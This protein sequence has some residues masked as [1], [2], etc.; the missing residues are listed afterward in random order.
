M[1]VERIV[2]VKF[3]EE[4]KETVCNFDKLINSFCSAMDGDCELCPIKPRCDHLADVMTI[5]KSY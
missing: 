4:E 3:E 2:K 5:L 1:K